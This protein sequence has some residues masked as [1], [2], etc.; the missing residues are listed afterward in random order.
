MAIQFKR[1]EPSP[2]SPRQ[3][4]PSPPVVL[5]VPPASK[6]EV[7]ERLFRFLCSLDEGR[8]EVAGPVV[9]ERA[10]WRALCQSPHPDLTKALRQCLN[11]LLVE[12]AP[13]ASRWGDFELSPAALGAALVA[14]TCLV[15][16][17]SQGDDVLDPLPGFAAALVETL[18]PARS[19][20]EM[21]ACHSVLRRAAESLPELAP[22]RAAVLHH[23]LN[24]CPLSALYHLHLHT[25][26]PLTP[27]A[28]ELL[29]GWD[30]RVQ[31]P[32][33]W[34]SLEDWLNTICPVL[35]QPAITAYL[36]RRWLALPETRPACRNLGL[37]LEALRRRGDSREFILTFYEAYDRWG[38][39][40]APEPG[41]GTARHWPVLEVIDRL[42]R[43]END[44]EAAI[45]L[46]RWGNEYFMKFRAL[47]QTV[48]AENGLPADFNL[49]TPQLIAGL[50]P[51]L[52][53]TG[54]VPGGP[55]LDLGTIEFDG[56]EQK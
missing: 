31:P 44:S 39:Q 14:Y 41:N 48:I 55:R 20:T 33:P 42:L 13:E 4:A 43:V 27:L 7:E 34:A 46:N 29:R 38:T 49:L 3:A 52:S 26:P 37:L 8:L 6:A 2:D 54:E 32:A 5:W 25:P 56:R 53:W 15:P 36:R 22:D 18:P 9:V 50:R 51:L 19:L 10:T 40:P 35:A 30:R 24:R 11:G 47:I 28:A 16:P 45:R 17:L 1:T 12:L 23:L 21:L